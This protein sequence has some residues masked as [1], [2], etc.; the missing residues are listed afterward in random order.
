MAACTPIRTR[1]TLA[2]WNWKSRARTSLTSVLNRL[3][4]KLTVP[5]SL[6]TYKAE[7]AERAFEYGVEIINDPSG[8]TFDP[9]LAKTVANANAGLILNHMRGTPEAWAKLPPLPD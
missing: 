1:L 6:D 9:D 8:L 3:R 4:D 7:I 5:L 2:H